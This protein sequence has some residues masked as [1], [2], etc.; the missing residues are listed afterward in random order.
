MTS[1]TTGASSKVD[2]AE[3]L[4]SERDFADRGGS[5]SQTPRGNP[6]I[7]EVLFLRKI[8]RARLLEAPSRVRVAQREVGAERASFIGDMV[9]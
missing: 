8:L 5:A 1:S 4:N 6:P 2:E 9:C 3:S 7:G